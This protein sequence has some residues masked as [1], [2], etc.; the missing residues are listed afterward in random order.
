MASQN[1][2]SMVIQQQDSAGVNVVNRTIGAFTYAGVVGGLQEYTLVTG[3][4]PVTW[5]L[6]TAI[7]LQF[8][9]RNLHATAVITV[10]WTAQGGSSQIAQRVG[11]GGTL[12]F[13]HT[14]TSATAGI[15]GLILNPD[16]ANTNLELF[17]GG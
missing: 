13:W 8:Y 1:N 15:T 16:T 10:T 12:V 2:L 7:V 3:S 11:P 14:A 9:L 17:L 4:S 6:P 5:V